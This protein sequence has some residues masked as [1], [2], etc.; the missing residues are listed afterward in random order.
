MRNTWKLKLGEV[1]GILLGFL[2]SGSVVAQENPYMFP[3]RPG[4]RNYL[5]GTMGEM[6]G[7]HFHGGIDI[8]TSG[9]TGLKI[10]AAADGYVSRIKVSGG[11]YGNA[12][13][14]AHPQ[15]GT[16]TVYGHL[17]NFGDDL[18]EYVLKEQYDRKRFAVDLYP[19][20]EQFK[21]KKGDFI[22]LS[23]NSGSS[24]GP[25]LH[26]EIRDQQQRPTNPLDYGFVEIQDNISPTIQRIGLKTLSSSSRV[27]QQ[28]GFFEFTPSRV[29]N[30]Y[31]I[32]KVIEVHGQIGLMIM[33]YDKLDGASNRN[34]IPHL[35]VDFDGKPI[36]DITID[37]VPFGKSRDVLCYRD[38]GVKANT[39]RSFRKLYI[40]D[41]NELEVYNSHKNRGIITIQD[42]LMHRVTV[43]LTDAH[44]NPSVVMMRLKGAK[45]QVEAAQNQRDFKPFRHQVFDNTLVFMGKKAEENGYFAHVFANRMSHE[46]SPSYYVDDY[47]VYL[48][49][50]QSGTPDSIHLCN[51]VIYPKLEMTVPSGVDF[52][53]YKDEFDLHFNAKT[54]YDTLYLK[55]DYVD[56]L[57]DNQE[58]FEI[59]ED[60]YPLKKAMKV[61]LKPKLPYKNKDKISAY[62]TTNLKNF[63]Y[64][65]GSWKNER[66]EFPTRTL[67]RYTLLADT[68]PPKI[69]IVQQNQHK[70]RCYITDDRS[71]IK[72]HELVIDGEWVLMNYDPK[73]NYIWSEK[74]EKDKPFQGKLELKV[75]DNVNNEKIY[76]TTLK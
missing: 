9:T 35:Q 46:L 8:K 21:V 3:V 6:R 30:E 58:F 44:G 24:S 25:H 41:G 14:I 73:R 2:F 59:S 50:L 39:G 67:G 56:E 4:E 70:F 10:Y 45:P 36:M 55:T 68:V 18:A 29:R 31:T 33:G 27:N 48:W 11:G 75:R 47:A 57:I 5:S 38:Y 20:K 12:L 74:L 51:D 62:Y 43:T 15:L 69:S 52:S 34:G 28:F 32:N 13:Y 65:G 49:D 16:T 61:S 7:S 19:G 26:F 23:G 42:T 60:I 22:A 66:F 76:S 54:L 17:K 72:D 63:S 71:G 64:Q 37:K 53:Y 1:I 40:D